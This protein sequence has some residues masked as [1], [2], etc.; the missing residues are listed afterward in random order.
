MRFLRS[1]QPAGVGNDVKCR[2]LEAAGL[3]DDFTEIRRSPSVRA[4][5][6]R[7]DH[8]HR[9][10][11]IFVVMDRCILKEHRARFRSV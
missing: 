9:R 6:V 8:Q 1:D 7:I 10:A 5:F 2:S 11:G 3:K 4:E